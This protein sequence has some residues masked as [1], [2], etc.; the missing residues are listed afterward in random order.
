MNVSE[1]LCDNS[2]EL[3]AITLVWY[4]NLIRLLPGTM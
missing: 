2:M 3:Q 4:G 1:F